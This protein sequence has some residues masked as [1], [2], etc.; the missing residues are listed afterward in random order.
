MSSS[1]T[2]SYAADFADV[3]AA[4]GRIAPH[5][6]RTPVLTSGEL[7]RRAGCRVHLKCENFQ[8]I[9]AFK[10]RGA[11]NCLMSLGDDDA[12]RCV[13]THS[14]GNHAQALALAALQLGVEAHIVMPENAPAVKRV[15]VEG[16]GGVIHPCRPT[17]ADRERVCDEVLAETGGVFVHP[18]NDPR[19]I[20]GQGTCALELLE[21]VPDLDAIIAPIGG[22]GLMSGTCIAARGMRPGLRL[23]AAEPTGADDAARS[24]A[25]GK[26]IPQT[27]PD[28][29]ADGLLTSLGDLTWPIVRDH[30]ERVITVDDDA[31]VSAMR[32][33][34][35]RMKIVVEPSGAVSVAAAL[36]L[37]EPGIERVGVIVSGGNVDLDRLPW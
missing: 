10:I 11:T 26:L 9:G 16:Y 19:V 7:D 29:I 30:V 6:H 32:L 25:A 35:Q 24:M 8:R 31:I 15:A 28:T 27:G 18:Y 5:V 4:A 33:V 13:V 37:D 14:S 2:T 12:G 36:A 21:Q 3:R 22:G 34:M 23:F 20:A 1:E 17:L